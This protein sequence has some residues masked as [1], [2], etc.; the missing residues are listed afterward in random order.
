[1]NVQELLEAVAAYQPIAPAT[2]KGW[3][4]AIR[5][6]EQMPVDEID[7]RFVVLRRSHLL[8]KGYKPGYVRTQLGY[9]QTIWEIG[10]EQMDLVDNNAWRGSLKGLKT[11][12]KKYPYLPLDHYEEAGLG[13]HPVFN[14]LYYTGCRV[15]EAA[16]LKPEDI[17]R[18]HDHPHFRIID[19]PIRGIKNDPSRREVPIHKKLE[20]F[21]DRFPFSENPKAGDNFSRYMKRRAGHSAHG[22]RDNVTTRM[23]QAGI[24]Y[25]IAQSILGHD[26]AGMT[27]SYGSVLLSDK[28]AA[29]QTI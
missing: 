22:L 10:K 19:N 27:A 5:G 9:C 25:S 6:F 4:Y 16:C 21:L 18:D 28:Y 12:K 11:K 14:F 15:S 8:A 23:R 20:P 24:E 1:M 13:T 26:A 17:V 7:K 2:R 3:Q 29:I